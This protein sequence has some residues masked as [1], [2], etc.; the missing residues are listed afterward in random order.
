MWLRAAREGRPTAKSFLPAKPQ[1][2]KAGDMKTARNTWFAG[3]YPYDNLEY[4]IVVMT[5]NGKSG[6]G[7]CC[8]IF[9]AIVEKL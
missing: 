1:P 4:A 7:D 5:E 2:R 3:V 8:P 6:A 9:R